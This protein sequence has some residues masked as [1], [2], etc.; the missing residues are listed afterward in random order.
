MVKNDTTVLLLT[1]HYSSIIEAEAGVL[2]ER[3]NHQYETH[4][5]L[6]FYYPDCSL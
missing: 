3:K 4:T 6:F 1:D 2:A 5:S